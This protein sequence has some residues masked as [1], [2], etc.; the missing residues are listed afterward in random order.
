MR[1]YGKKRIKGLVDGRVSKRREMQDAILWS[2]DGSV[3]RV[4]VQGSSN[5]VVAHYPK[6]QKSAPLWLRPG[7]AV[8]VVFKEGIRGYV[9]IVGEGR[10]IPSAQSG[11]SF[12]DIGSVS[13]G[14]LSGLV[15]T[16]T[17][18]VS[19]N[20]EVSAGSYRIDGV[21]YYM[22]EVSGGYIVMYDPPPMVMGNLPFVLNGQVSYELSAAPADGWFRYDIIVA[23]TDGDLGLIEGNEVTSDPVMPTVPEDHVLVEFVLRV[24]G[25]TNV[26]MKRV[27]A[28]YE[29]P[30]PVTLSMP[31]GLFV[32]SGSS[33]VGVPIS[34][35]DQYGHAVSS[36]G[37]WV[38]TLTKIFGT[39]DIWSAQSGWDSDEVVQNL[40]SQ[41]AYGFIYRRD[42]S[43][44]EHSPF[45]Q[46]V[47]I[48][49]KNPL[50]GFAGISLRNLL[51]EH[52]P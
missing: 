4:R 13:D 20:V 33:F 43:V 51:G 14:I 26:P 36:S 30:Y 31:V 40:V 45:L 27:G 29:T 24:G 41:S 19:N 10:A 50:Y 9:E 17:D 39:G 21:I 7:N 22:T 42:P 35:I 44:E 12:P 52:I 8:R 11:G 25:D 32:L 23:G 16:S 47:M 18:P 1:S 38:L 49:D 2:V 3:C 34:V 46:A 6:N 37:G 15:V 48:G 5:N 28:L